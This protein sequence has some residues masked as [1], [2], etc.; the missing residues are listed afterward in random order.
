M[1][2][3]EFQL[4]N[5]IDPGQL[6]LE[7]CRQAS[8][9]FK[10][11]ERAIEAKAIADKLKFSVDVTQAKVQAVIRDDPP[12]Y[13][14]GKIT[15]AAINAA[16]Q[17][18]PDYTKAQDTYLDARKA[19]SLLD[20]A[21]ETMEQRKRMIEILVTLHG[22]QYFAGPSTPRDL[23]SDWKQYQEGISNKVTETQASRARKRVRKEA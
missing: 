11:A 3:N 1:D 8:L 6:D 22:Q 23:V 10:W 20:V 9:F 7:A 13:G 17:I 2:R 12:K 5:E 16:V 21:R 19:A 18:H 4:D 15:E 14:I